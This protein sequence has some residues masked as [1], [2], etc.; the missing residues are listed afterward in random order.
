MLECILLGSFSKT[1]AGIKLHT[2]FD[3][4][5]Q[6]PFLLILQKQMYTMLMRDVI[7][8]EPF[9]YYIFDCVYVDFDRLFRITKANAYF[10]V[11]AK[12]NVK[13]KRMDSLKIDKTTGIKYDQIGKIEGFYTSKDYPEKIRK[14][15]FFDTENKKMLVFLTN[16][17]ELSAQN[18]AL[19]YKPKMAIR[20]V[21]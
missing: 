3:I 19:L 10:V 8:Y 7:D 1:K 9:A 20:I 4:N 6:V 11:R 21:L 2:L 16:N 18:I 12:S 13:F 5:T 15:K 17:F 14:V